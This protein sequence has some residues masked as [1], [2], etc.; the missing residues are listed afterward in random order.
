MKNAISRPSE[1]RPVERVRSARATERRA[2]ILDRASE[3]FGQKGYGRTT[4][5]D[6]AGA[7]GVKREAIYYYFD[8]KLDILCEIITP[9]SKRLVEDLAAIMRR[10]DVSPRDR[11]AMAVRNHMSGFNPDFL[12]LAVV[13]R[14]LDGQDDDGR[15]SEIRRL[16]RAY[17]ESWIDLV[18]EGQ[19]AGCFAGHLDPRLTAFSILGMCNAPSTWFQPSGERSMEEL[20]ETLVTVT[21]NGVAP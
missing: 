19:Q 17:Q 10:H 6:I 5:D 14:E 20:V 16:W 9:E 18:R 21:L 8:H 2:S 4:L 3:I 15:V 12:Q 1:R 7:V 13:L 11:L